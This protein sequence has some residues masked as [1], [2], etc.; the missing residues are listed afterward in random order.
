MFC[1]NLPLIVQFMYCC[2]YGDVCPL[3]IKG[4]LTYLLTLKKG[5][6]SVCQRV[7]KKMFNFEQHFKIL[8]QLHCSATEPG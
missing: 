7:N 5:I 8:K 3:L 1:I 6:T 2:S 4:L